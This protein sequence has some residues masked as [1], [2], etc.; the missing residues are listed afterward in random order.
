MS[1]PN[2]PYG[3][4]RSSTPYNP[5]FSKD[6]RRHNPWM[7]GI[8]EVPKDD[9]IDKLQ[10]KLKE[11][12]EQERIDE[13]KNRVGICINFGGGIPLDYF[14]ESE[15]EK[16][17][18]IKDKAQKLKIFKEMMGESKGISRIVKGYNK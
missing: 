16:L 11:N 18:L 12:Q 10:Q 8:E 15:M 7:E 4:S 2:Y 5:L 1:H 17:A 3:P 14:I 13:I 9:I 6:W